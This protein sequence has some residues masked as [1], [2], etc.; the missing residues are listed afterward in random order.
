MRI[1]QCVDG[2]A[3]CAG[4]RQ[5]FTMTTITMTMTNTMS[6]EMAMIMTMTMTRNFVSGKSWKAKGAPPAPGFLLQKIHILAQI[7]FNA[8]SIDGR[9]FTLEK[10]ARSLFGEDIC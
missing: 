6:M 2:H 4:C 8:R 5:G 9:N 10:M 3:I 7:F 1:W